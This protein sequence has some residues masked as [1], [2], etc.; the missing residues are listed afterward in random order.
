MIGDDELFD[1]HSHE[2][3]GCIECGRITTQASWE[4]G[5][6]VYLCPLCADDDMFGFPE[7]EEVADGGSE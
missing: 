1:E 4:D 2:P 7:R 3:H 5:R 6:L